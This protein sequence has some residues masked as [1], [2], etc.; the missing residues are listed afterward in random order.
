MKIAH[1]KKTT[2]ITTIGTALAL[3]ALTSTA[4][5]RPYDDY[6]KVTEVNPIYNTV[7]VREPY[8]DCHYETRTV[9]KRS[10]GSA[11]PKILGA[12]IGGAIGNEL[13]HNKSN[14]RA[15]AVLGA[16]LGGSIAHDISRNNRPANSTRTVTE[17]V[18]E[19]RHHS[20]YE[21]T[22]TGY[23]VSYKYHGRIYHT[24]MDT[25]PGDRIPVA[26]DVQPVH[27]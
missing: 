15:G 17:E 10:S 27:Y 1:S 24:V 4:S 16:V 19:T 6:A 23:D 3:T 26:V 25:H 9:N 12:L 7:T 11:T 13:G 2:L 21:K 20:R 8:Q 14:K 5:A 22:V 18:C